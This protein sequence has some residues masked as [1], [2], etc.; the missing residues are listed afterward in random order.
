M[1][2]AEVREGPGIYFKNVVNVASA[3][4]HLLIEVLLETRE[5]VPDFFRS[6]QV[7]DGVGDG[8]VVLELQ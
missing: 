6:A 1:L 8:V 2:F 4:R 5:N 3:S 7:G